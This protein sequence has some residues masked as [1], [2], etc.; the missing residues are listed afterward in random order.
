M[1]AAAGSACARAVLLLP[2]GAAV[3][4]R[5]DGL[6]RA[7]TP[8]PADLTVEFRWCLIRAWMQVRKQRARHKSGSAAH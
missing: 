4:A 2:S 7:Y 1:G 6:L 3:D 5:L 8:R